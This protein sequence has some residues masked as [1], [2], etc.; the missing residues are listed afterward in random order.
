MIFSKTKYNTNFD[1][2]VCCIFIKQ[3]CSES[4][5]KVYII[6]SC[7]KYSTIYDPTQY[8]LIFKNNKDFFE[9]LWRETGPYYIC[10]VLAFSPMFTN[11]L[12]QIVNNCFIIVHIKRYFRLIF[13]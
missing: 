13:F 10:I 9:L 1:S 6:E 8:S 7:N 3:L 4:F 12:R 2:D 11:F 5:V